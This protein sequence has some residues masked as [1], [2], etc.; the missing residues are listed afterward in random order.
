MLAKVIDGSYCGPSG[1]SA[2]FSVDIN[3]TFNLGA[4]LRHAAT[5]IDGHFAFYNYISCIFVA[6]DQ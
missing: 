5:F 2:R 4:F 6:I 3:P 1:V